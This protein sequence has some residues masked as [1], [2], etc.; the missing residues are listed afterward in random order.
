MKFRLDKMRL[1]DLDRAAIS[2]SHFIK[3]NL[4]DFSN[5]IR[6]SPDTCCR[7]SAWLIIKDC[8]CIHSPCSQN[9]IVDSMSEG[10]EAYVLVIVRDLCL[11]SSL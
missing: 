7:I 9:G 11:Q 8:L 6:K 2:N 3:C 4:L 10:I 1:K 5:S